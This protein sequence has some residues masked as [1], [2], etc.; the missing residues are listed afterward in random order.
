[1]E[2]GEDEGMIVMVKVG[3]MVVVFMVWRHVE[4]CFVMVV[5]VMAVKMKVGRWSW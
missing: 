3:F 2:V 4:I 1:M 5:V